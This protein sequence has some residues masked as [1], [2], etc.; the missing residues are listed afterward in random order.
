LMFAA[1]CNAGL[2][3]HPLA[4]SIRFLP[5]SH[6]LPNLIAVGGSDQASDHWFFSNYGK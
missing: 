3:H 4:P 2:Y 6:L 5:A 1:A